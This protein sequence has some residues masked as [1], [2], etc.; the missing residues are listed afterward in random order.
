MEY[1]YMLTG[2]VYP[3]KKG[4]QI[5]ETFSNAGIPVLAP[6]TGTGIQIST[7]GNG[8]MDNAVGVTL[9]TA[10][11]VTAQQT[12]GTSAEREV[13]VIISPSAVWRALM[14]NGSTE[15]TAL[16]IR[17]ATSA[18]ANG[19]SAVTGDNWSSPE[20]VEGVIWGYSGSNA[21][22]KRKITTTSSTTA[23]VTV[24]FDNPV[25]IGD[26]FLFA[27]YWFLDNTTNGISLTALLTQAN[28]SIVVG[29]GGEVRII[30]MELGDI[31]E[32]GRTKSY[33]LFIFDDHALRDAT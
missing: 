3:L 2:G 19:T 21:G 26:S 7:T 12:D 13:D 9:D 22:Q 5:Q 14:S 20:M 8:G 4:F 1:A 29:T 30:D 17:T 23:T 10:T 11:Y 27:P 18:T 16:A 6:N 33:V 31:A 24:P 28:S 25:A 15:G 32:E